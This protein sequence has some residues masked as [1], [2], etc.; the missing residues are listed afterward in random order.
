MAGVRSGLKSGFAAGIV[1]ALIVLLGVHVLLGDVLAGWFSLPSPQP[2]AWL[3]L[4]AVAWWG[5]ARA[6]REQPEGW[7]NVSVVGLLAGLAHGLV[8][9]VLVGVFRV[10]E[11]FIAVIV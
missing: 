3:L 11:V 1:N 2:G 8:M 10:M 6:L 4:L 7:K 9:G 5:G